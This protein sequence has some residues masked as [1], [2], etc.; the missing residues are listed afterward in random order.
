MGKDKIVIAT[1]IFALAVATDPIAAQPTAERDDITVERVGGLARGTLRIAKDPNT[2]ILYTIG[3]NGEITRW[4]ADDDGFAAER[5]FTSSDHGVS[6]VAGFAIGPDGSFYISSNQSSGNFNVATITK[7]EADGSGGY[8]WFT[9]AQT[10]PIEQC[11]CIFNHQVNGLAVSPD[12]MY[13]YINSGS[14]TDHGEIQ[15]TNGNFPRCA[16]PG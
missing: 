6:G 7:G 5:A 9:L 14:R 4:A 11:D 2:N 15:D 12:N 10:E 16:R 3:Q 1:A 8:D 13:V